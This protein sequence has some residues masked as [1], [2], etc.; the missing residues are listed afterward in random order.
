MIP[1][2]R[3][4]S[5]TQSDREFASAAA[6]W[7]EE[8]VPVEPIP[9]IYSAEGQI[10]YREWERRVFDA[11]Y[12]AVHWPLEYGGQGR[13]LRQYA[14]F[15][16]L[17]AEAG[18]PE[19]FNLNG[20]G[21]LGPVMLEVATAEQ[22]AR[23][24]ER[25]LT[26]D[27]IWGQGF[28][29]PD[30]GSDLASIR[31]SARWDGDRYIVDGHKIWTT[32]GTFAD[33]MFCLV[34]RQGVE[35][36]PGLMFLMI[37]LRSPGVEIRPIR[38]LHGSAGFAEVFFSGV[39]VPVEC[40]LGDEGDG[41]SLAMRMLGHE[42]A[43]GV[44][45]YARLSRDVADLIRLAQDLDVD[46]SLKDEI[47]QVYVECE[48]YRQ[49][50][51]GVLD[52]IDHGGHIGPEGSIGKLAWSEAQERVFTLGIAAMGSLGHLTADS[53]LVAGALSTDSLKIWTHWHRRYWYARAATIAGGTSEIQRN[54]IAER[55]LGLPRSAT[56]VTH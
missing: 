15:Q 9:E 12:A 24:L 39:T 50:M 49:Y 30:S 32:Y 35:G 18:A 14:L 5:S 17:Y 2:T 34:R 4:S 6:Q 31:T 16:E 21:V 52:D 42:R 37:D 38:Q 33:W 55:V 56:V 22:K 27:D 3:D 29:E 44:A 36:I 46:D 45:S 10:A 53:P 19:R 20:V 8:N 7:L 1:V 28:S 11:G 48:G 47:T 40:R 26:G 25:I 13:P 51:Y 41:W 23:W 43:T 54:V